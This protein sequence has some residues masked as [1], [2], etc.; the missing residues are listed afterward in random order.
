M[1]EVDLSAALRRFPWFGHGGA[2]GPSGPGG[3]GRRF[4]LQS[5]H[6]DK[7]AGSGHEVGAQAGSLDTPVARLAERSGGLCPAEDIFNAFA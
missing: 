5:G 1:F 2:L 6:A 7:V 4:V 3:N